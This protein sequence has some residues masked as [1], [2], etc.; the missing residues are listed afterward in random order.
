MNGVPAAGVVV[1]GV[2]ENCVATTGGGGGGLLL[3]QPPKTLAV[4]TN[5]RANTVFFITLC[6]PSFSLALIPGIMFLPVLWSLSDDEIKKSGPTRMLGKFGELGEF[7][8]I[9]NRRNND[10]RG[11]YHKPVR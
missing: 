3:P 1:L 8:T 10:C 6:Q 2:T 4:L 7:A 5:I 11:C 9:D